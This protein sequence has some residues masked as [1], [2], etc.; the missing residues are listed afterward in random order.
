[1]RKS[2]ELMCDKFVWPM[3][4]KDIADYWKSCAACQKTNKVAERRALI[5]IR[6]VVSQQFSYE[7]S[8]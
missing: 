4:G 8:I 5:V 6:P 2:Q 1:M 3:M 7:Y